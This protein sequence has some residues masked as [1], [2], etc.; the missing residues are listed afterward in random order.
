M[1]LT[2]F[3]ILWVI[4]LVLFLIFI[5]GFVLYSDNEADIINEDFC[6]GVVTVQF[7]DKNFCNGRPFTCNYEA[8]SCFYIRGGV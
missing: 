6:N 1:D 3:L 4:S 2:D 7:K 5:M 8:K